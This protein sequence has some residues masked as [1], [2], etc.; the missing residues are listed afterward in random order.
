MKVFKNIQINIPFLDAINQTPSYAKFIKDVTTVKRE[1]F[2]PCEATFVAQASC[3]IQ[4]T[5]AS[6]YKDPKSLT[7]SVRIRDQVMDR[8]LLD[9]RA[10][11]NLLPYS[12]KI[13]RFRGVRTH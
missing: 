11:V 4:R 8:C 1:I 12:V 5:I 6:K 2:V 9:L 10:S 13:I 3:L 7:I